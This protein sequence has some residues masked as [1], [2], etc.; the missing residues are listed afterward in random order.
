LCCSLWL[1]IVYIGIASSRVDC[2]DDPMK[3]CIELEPQTC[4]CGTPQQV[5]CRFDT[6]TGKCT[7]KDCPAD[8]SLACTLVSGVQGAQSQCRCEQRQAPA[9]CQWDACNQRCTTHRCSATRTAC[10]PVARSDG[11][12]DCQC[13]AQAAHSDDNA[14]K[15]S[16]KLSPARTFVALGANLPTKLLLGSGDGAK[17]LLF[18]RHD[19]LGSLAY[20]P[21]QVFKLL[22]SY[23]RLLMRFQQWWLVNRDL[24]KPPVGVSL[25][26]DD[27]GVCMRVCM[28]VYIHMKTIF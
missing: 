13:A 19:K 27:V 12:M 9:P 14:I 1:A 16:S 25:S 22:M 11:T 7:R 10:V 3:A 6:A 20:G 15:I 23:R 2:P 24:A 4:G 5:P 17:L 21:D 28:R 18:D 26:F 8:P